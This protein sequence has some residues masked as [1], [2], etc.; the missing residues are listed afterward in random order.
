MIAQVQRDCERMG[1]MYRQKRAQLEKRVEKL[2]KSRMAR[3]DQLWVKIMEYQVGD[4]VYRTNAF[5][6]SKETLEF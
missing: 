5:R 4:F 6:S 1:Q 2:I 3:F